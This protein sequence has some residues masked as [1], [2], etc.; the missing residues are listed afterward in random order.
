MGTPQTISNGLPFQSES[1]H[2]SLM[3]DQDVASMK[4]SAYLTEL[5]DPSQVAAVSMPVG[6]ELPS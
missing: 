3:V 2:G 4:S 1:C 5:A 6:L